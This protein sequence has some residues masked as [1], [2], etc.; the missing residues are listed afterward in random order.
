MSRAKMYRFF[1]RCYEI[2]YVFAHFS[3]ADPGEELIFVRVRGMS[4]L[5]RIMHI[6][7]S[8]M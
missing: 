4:T 2:Y 6:Q 5:R 3:I 1:S 7:Y 8:D